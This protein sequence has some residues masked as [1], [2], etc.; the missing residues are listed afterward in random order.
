M[1]LTMS[2]NILRCVFPTIRSETA[3]QKSLAFLIWLKCSLL[4]KIL[5]HYL[6]NHLF[7][8]KKEN[9]GNFVLAKTKKN[10]GT[11]L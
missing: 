2:F 11:S 7:P 3:Q 10:N 4:L 5:F 8:W 9:E 6:L 1:L